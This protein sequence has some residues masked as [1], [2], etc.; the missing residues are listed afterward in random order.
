VTAL[1]CNEIR[2]LFA[3]LV[4][5]PAGDQRTG[6]AGHGG[7]ARTRDELKPATTGDK[8]PSSHDRHE[9][10]LEYSRF[11]LLSL[12]AL[13]IRYCRSGSLVVLAAAAR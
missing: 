7:A 11:C 13:V 12:A 1:T 9:T 3:V 2:H 8:P 10:P 4:L 5:R 6:C